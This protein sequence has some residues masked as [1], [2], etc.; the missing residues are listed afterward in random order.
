MVA[1]SGW[2]IPAPLHTPATVAGPPSSKRAPASFWNASVVWMAPRKRRPASGSGESCAS[3]WV[4]PARTLSI[5]SLR[6]MT[7]VEQTTTSS[8]RH[9]RARATCSHMATASRWPC[10]PV[11]AFALPLFTTTARMRPPLFWRCSRLTP[12]GAAANR[13]WVKMPAALMGASA[14]SSATSGRPLSL[15][16]AATPEARSPGTWV[17]V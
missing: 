9:D 13:F 6:P 1:M 10:S 17:R 2:I 7:P 15:M 8:V 4:M 3:A 12:T 5:G 11:Q 14:T 16:P